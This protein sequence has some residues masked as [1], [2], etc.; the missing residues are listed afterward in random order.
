MT[1]GGKDELLLLLDSRPEMNNA[2]NPKAGQPSYPL[3]S[4]SPVDLLVFRSRYLEE[5]GPLGFLTILIIMMIT[6][7]VITTIIIII[8]MIIIVL[9]R[10]LALWLTPEMGTVSGLPT[11]TFI[12]SEDGGDGGHDRRK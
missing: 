12:V 7:I 8:I 4:S 10:P 11:M 1:D 2:C 3:T 6:I 9:N 5:V